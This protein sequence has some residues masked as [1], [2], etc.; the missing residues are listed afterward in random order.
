MRNKLL[1]PLVALCIVGIATNAQNVE[2]PKTTFGFKAGANF[3]NFR[4]KNP[5]NPVGLE[6]KSRTGVVGGFFIDIPFSRL[7]SI[8]PNFLYS[9]M[10]SK[11]KG[12][13]NSTSG[14]ADQKLNYFSMP[15]LLK[16]NLS[17]HFSF[18][19]GPQFDFLTSVKLTTD[20]TSIS[21]DGKFV[22]NDIAATAGIQFWMGRYLGID[23][24]YIYGT[25]NIAYYNNS[26]TANFG[27]TYN[28]AFQV[29]ANFRFGKPAYVAPVV[30]PVAPVIPPVADTDGDGINDND[31][32]C[33]SVAGLAKYGGCPIPDTDGDG[34][35]DEQD[36]CPTVAGL[37]KYN[38]CPIPDTDGDGI[39]DE[40][41]KC[42]NQAG[43]AK[44]GGCP[45]PDTDGDGINDEEDKCP[46]RPGLA[47]NFGC[48]VIGIKAYEI[49]FQSGKAVLLP[50]SKLLLD[51]VVT[52][53]K[54]NTG[55]NVTIDGHTDNSGTDKINDPLSVKRAEST[56][57]YLVSKGID[58]AR[59]TT[60]GFGSKNPVANNKT[61]DGRKKNRRIEIKIQ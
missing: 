15:L 14:E 36:K 52:Y 31:D 53:L 50:K 42:P 47:D 58:A 10:G 1:L 12:V 48:P 44:Y 33:P 19:V 21:N 38:G 24:R 41:D 5:K 9:Q 11:L 43:V 30:V 2:K 55:V 46:N 4:L 37:A 20:N 49:A 17:P 34:I 27:K 7:L 61:A 54:T 25:K 26:T 51:S 22:K 56:K 60:A 57:T 16:F 28:Q 40:E 6:S 45:I 3:S 18:L 8:E 35:N 59:M 32:K 39:N 29:T 23:A 13:S